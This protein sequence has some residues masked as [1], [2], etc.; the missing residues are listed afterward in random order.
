MKE[1][2]NFF[3]GRRYSAVSTNEMQVMGK[4]KTPKSLQTKPS[5]KRGLSVVDAFF[6]EREAGKRTR[7]PKGKLKSLADSS[8]NHSKNIFKCDF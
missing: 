8:R 2:V 7:L 6:H 1:V 5:L 4:S 3:K